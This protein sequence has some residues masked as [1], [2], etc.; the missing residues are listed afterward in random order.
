MGRLDEAIAQYRKVLK[1]Q[2]DFAEAHNNLG[3]A[4]KGRGQIEEAMA[5]YQEAVKI[6]PDLAEAH[7]NLGGSLMSQGRIDEAIEHFRQALG[8][9]RM[10][11]PTTTSGCVDESR[12]DRRGDRTLP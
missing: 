5:Q 8:S 3:N 10:P 2:P 12:A 9:S 7:N 6:D 4:L 1:I 11:T